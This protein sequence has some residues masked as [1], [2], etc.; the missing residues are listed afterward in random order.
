MHITMGPRASLGIKT[1]GAPC[2]WIAVVK[3]H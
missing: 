3:P 2:G 1:Q